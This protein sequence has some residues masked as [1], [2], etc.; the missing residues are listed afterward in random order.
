MGFRRGSGDEKLLIC[1]AC[2]E[3]MAISA[4]FC[5]ECGVS[6]AV[7]I[8]YEAAPEAE[9]ANSEVLNQHDQDSRSSIFS[10]LNQANKSAESVVARVAKV[11]R[12]R[13]YF[14]SKYNAFTNILSSR[15]KLVYTFTIVMLFGTMYSLTQSFIFSS[16]T[17]DVFSEKYIN[18]VASRD[19]DM[20]TADSIYFPNPKSLPILPVKY[21]PWSEVEQITWKTDSTWNGW[22]GKAE[23]TFTPVITQKPD[24]A[25]SFYLNLKAEYKVKWGIFR[26]IDWV[27]SEPV[28]TL[29][30][31][32]K[33]EKGQ[34]IVFNGVSAGDSNEPKL[35]ELEYALFPGPVDIVLSGEGF[36][37]E[38]TFSSFVGTF[39][40]ISPI[41]EEVSFGLSAA[42]V[43]SAQDKV[44]KD[45]DSCLKRECGR[46]PY[47]SQG[48]FDFSNWPDTYLYVDTFNTG[49]S[50]SASCDAPQVTVNSFNGARLNMTCTVS[51]SAS[52]K[53]I[54]Y[55]IFFTTYYDTGYSS[56]TITLNVSADLA[57][58]A[59]SSK[60][61]VSGIEIS[62]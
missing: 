10:I 40:L 57:P 39:G 49:W 21:Q 17:T 24:Y 27:S 2:G 14:S 59:N 6:R 47:V 18:A 8:G 23:V 54:L 26:Q 60:V 43:Y 25:K 5:I 55:R 58:L 16:Q 15:R 38:R 19:T 9:L 13:N 30:L 50:E 48:D 44:Q 56:K 22:L 51:V 36:T 11:P 61:K 33:I 52:I 3:P 28:S 32:R 31:P 53:W 41:F 12:I 29:Q 46:L 1:K 37:K 42:Q 34:Q 4:E 45:V 35:N 20:I 62:G 7:A